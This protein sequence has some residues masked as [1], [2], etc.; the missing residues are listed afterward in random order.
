MH[1]FAYYLT[2]AFVF[3]NSLFSSFLPL[4]FRK[5]HYWN[6]TTKALEVASTLPVLLCLYFHV[7]PSGNFCLLPLT[8]SQDIYIC[9][10]FKMQFKSQFLQGS[11]FSRLDLERALPFFELQRITYGSDHILLCI[12]EVSVVSQM[13]FNALESICFI[14]CAF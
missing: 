7:S 6:P 9:V 10:S 12:T 13:R 8:L 14:F 11:S 3:F 4:P 2:S 1:T 5:L